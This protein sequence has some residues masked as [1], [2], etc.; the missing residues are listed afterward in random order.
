MQKGPYIEI[1]SAH[2]LAKPM[3]NMTPMPR[4]A[5]EDPETI[6]KIVMMLIHEKQRKPIVRLYNSTLRNS[7]QIF[8]LQ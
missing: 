7:F 2:R 3:I 1:A 5:P 4:D 8:G 6:P